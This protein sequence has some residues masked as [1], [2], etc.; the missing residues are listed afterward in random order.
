MCELDTKRYNYDMRS[1]PTLLYVVYNIDSKLIFSYNMSSHPEIY[2][3]L[4][5]TTLYVPKCIEEYISA[6]L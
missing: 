1:S 2:F 5:K 6:L 4:Y 3:K